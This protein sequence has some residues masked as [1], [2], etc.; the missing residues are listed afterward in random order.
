MATL[1]INREKKIVTWTVRKRA[2]FQLFFRLLVLYL[3]SPIFRNLVKHSI[4]HRRSIN[5][6][7]LLTGTKAYLLATNSR[8]TISGFDSFILPLKRKQW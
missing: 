4:R 7:F 3:R 2:Y 6:R 1:S 5:S 8:I